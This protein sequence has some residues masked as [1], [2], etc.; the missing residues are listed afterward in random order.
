MMSG[1]T[2]PPVAGFAGQNGSADGGAGGDHFSRS[3]LP[4]RFTMFL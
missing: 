1:G 2:R 4:L 3:S